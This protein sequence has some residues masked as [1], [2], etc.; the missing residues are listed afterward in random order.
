MFT[1]R[2]RGFVYPAGIDKQPLPPFKI[3][4]LTKCEVKSS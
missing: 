2:I 1:I 4:L 3:C